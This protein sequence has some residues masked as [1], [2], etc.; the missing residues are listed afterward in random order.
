M[1][2]NQKMKSF[3]FLCAIIPVFIT[4]RA[5]LAQML[6]KQ[7]SPDHVS[8]LWSPP[9]IHSCRMPC[10]RLPNFVRLS[11]IIKN[12]GMPSQ[13]DKFV[14]TMNGEDVIDIGE[15]WLRFLVKLWTF[16]CTLKLRPMRRLMSG[17]Y[18]GLN[19]NRLL[20]H[21]SKKSRNAAYRRWKCLPRANY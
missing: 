5:N 2:S 14:R 20:S 15:Y 16:N 9:N 8:H 12:A 1:I 7:K 3:Y 19:Y 17:S 10:Q 11:T 6:Q 13:L 21:W 4:K 18:V